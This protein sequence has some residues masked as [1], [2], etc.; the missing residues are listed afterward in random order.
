MDKFFNKFTNGE[1]Y[2]NLNDYD[3]LRRRVRQY[4]NKRI[5]MEIERRQLEQKKETWYIIYP[6]KSKLFTHFKQDFE[7]FW[8]RCCNYD[9]TIDSNKLNLQFIRRSKYRPSI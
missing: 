8:L 7:R 6:F 3:K 1:L 4:D 5:Q 9:N 2:F